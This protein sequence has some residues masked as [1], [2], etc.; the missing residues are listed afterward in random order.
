MAAAAKSSVRRTVRQVFIREE[1]AAIHEVSATP[2]RT[3]VTST[4]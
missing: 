2:P 4:A 1:R 3:D